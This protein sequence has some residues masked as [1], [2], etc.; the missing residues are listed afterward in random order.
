MV[1]GKAIE[2][3]P[4]SAGRR[5]CRVAF[6][7]RER[8]F[9]SG[10]AGL[11]ARWPQA[12]AQGYIDRGT[13]LLVLDLREREA[14]GGG[15]DPA[16][17]IAH[18]DDEVLH[19]RIAAIGLS[20]GLSGHQT[21]LLEA[22]VRVGSIRE[23][24]EMIGISYTAARNTLAEIKAKT[25]FSALAPMVGH[26]LVL[27]SGT[28]DG[29]SDAITRHDL[30][31]LTDRQFTIAAGLSIVPS[32]RTLADRLG[33][34]EAVL[35]AELKDIFLILGVRNAGQLA[36]VAAE[37]RLP[38]TSAHADF[39]ATRAMRLLPEASV[40]DDHGRVIAWSDF[41]PADG[42]PVFILH[43]TIT[44][45]APP[46]R[47]VAELRAAGFRPLA[48]DRPGFGGTDRAADAR[49]PFLAAAHDF[50]YLC[51][52]LGLDRTD[53]IARGAGQ[54]ALVLAHHAAPLIGRAVL[55]NP[56]PG[57]DYTSVDRG[58]LGAVK[59][60]FIKNAAGTAAL[61][62]LLSAFAT[63]RRLHEGMIRSFAGSAPD[64]AAIA[65]EQIVADYLRA[66]RGFAE[67]HIAG[68]VA[69]Q[70]AWGKG[71]DVA[72]LPGMDGW[73]IVQGAHFVLHEP[74]DALDYWRRILP[75]TPVTMVSDAGQL[76]AYSHPGQVIEALLDPPG[77]T[78]ALWPR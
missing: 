61:I 41:G 34:S 43:S 64:L 40:R 54:A 48:I 60:R 25:G 45:R 68:Y 58:P 9:M 46:T 20:F 49:D 6:L 35:K 3:Q 18:F 71:Y 29:T 63:P 36:R 51:R 44:A 1:T 26:M 23:A 38:L 15:D 62:R 12:A 53:I 50:A 65:D 21:R 73:R 42:R 57:I 77:A 69:E 76:L 8:R 55:V 10:D 47:L 74:R 4:G 11:A 31:G 39:S 56:T 75:D 30:F 70:I 13:G 7:D 33:L 5:Y 78:M 52:H 22:L 24:A 17:L 67:G 32:R 72:P 59:R 16:Y 37:A 2:R 27:I 14:D 66:V 19:E 28:P